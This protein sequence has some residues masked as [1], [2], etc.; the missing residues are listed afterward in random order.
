MRDDHKARAPLGVDA[1]QQGKHFGR[2][3]RVKVARGLIG[4]H[5]R[6][7][8]DQ[9]TRN[10]HALLHA[11]RQLGRALVHGLGQAHG[12]EQAARMVAVG[13]ADAALGHEG[14]QRDVLQRRERGQQVVKLE[15]KAQRAAAAQGQGRIVQALHFFTVQPKA[16][17]GHAL[18]Q[19]Q[20]VEQGALARARRPHQRDEFAP[21][22][23]QVDTVQYLGLAGAAQV[24]AFAHGVERDQ[25]GGGCGV[26]GVHNVPPRLTC[27]WLAPGPTPP[28]AAPGPQ[29]PARRT[30]RQSARSAAP[31]AAATQ[32]KT[33]AGRPSRARSG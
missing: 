1:A 21:A 5:Q 23:L 3:S 16:A 24:V 11:A 20:D 27:G 31:W 18:Q 13:G 7:V 25:L 2:R 4:Q 19:A 17:R 14:R 8:H 28:R 32:L 6:R 9:R 26:H 12:V 15:H 33:A 29:P 10:G 30:P 22:H